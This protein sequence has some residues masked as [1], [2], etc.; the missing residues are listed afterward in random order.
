MKEEISRQDAP[1]GANPS[2]QE[3]AEKNFEQKVT[4]AVLAPRR[5]RKIMKNI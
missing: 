5:S 3:V 4:L 1:A 2:R